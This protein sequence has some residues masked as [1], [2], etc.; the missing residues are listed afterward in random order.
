MPF[1]PKTKDEIVRK[2]LERLR[3]KTNITQLSP[4]GKAR[5][6]IET[7]ASEQ[8]Q[9]QQLFDANLV[10]PFIRYADG[11][12]LDYFG[13]MLNLPRVTASHAE[14]TG[15]NFFFYVDSG[16]FGD[17]NNSSSF[18]IPAG[19]KIKTPTLTEDIIT[20]GITEQSA[21]EFILTQDVT[22]EA[23][24]S[25]IYCSVRA[26]AEGSISSVPRNVLTDHGFT[27]YVM[28]AKKALKCTNKYS[29][30]NGVGRESDRAYKYRLQNIFGARALATKIAIRLAALSVPGVNDVF[31]M[32]CEQGPGTFALYV[33]SVTPTA[34]PNL[35]ARVSE[36]IGSVVSEGIRAFVSGPRTLG[37]EFVIAIHWDP[38]AK[39]V[40]IAETYR[41]I[42]EEIEDVMSYNQ[43]GA[44]VDLQSILGFISS[45]PLVHKVGLNEPNAFEKVFIYKQ[46]PNGIGI[47]RNVHTGNVIQPLYNEKV[48]LETG[49]RY[50]GIQ[51]LTF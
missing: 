3:N 29:I 45:N 18:V 26:Q 6:L 15:E 27:G 30:D 41:S 24:N 17:I 42:R 51:F 34:S 19:T 49:T 13:D 2:S 20:P 46:G 47:T 28:Y 21:V 16:T 8:A 14:A 32:N 22:C 7:V 36:A 10:Q 38:N 39:K 37:A 5:F 43:M 31:M 40:E 11:K 33:D 9:Q 1:F 25:F 12:F 50:R 35:I 44:E 48:I 4:G 23:G